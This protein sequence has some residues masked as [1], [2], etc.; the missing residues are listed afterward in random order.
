MQ[1][2][3]AYHYFIT[4]RRFHI[5]F[6]K[7]YGNKNYNPNVDTLHEYPSYGAKSINTRVSRFQIMRIPKKWKEYIPILAGIRGPQV[8]VLYLPYGALI[9][10][11]AKKVGIATTIIVTEDNLRKSEADIDEMVLNSQLNIAVYFQWLEKE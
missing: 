9:N 6:I 5:Y 1:Q 11:R 3:T 4:D 7:I 10:N 2:E 8:V